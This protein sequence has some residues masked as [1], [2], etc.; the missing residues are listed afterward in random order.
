MSFIDDLKKPLPSA[1]TRQLPEDEVVH[2]SVEDMDDNYGVEDLDNMGND[3]MKIPDD[4]EKPDS[5]ELSP[6]ED[7]EADALINIAATPVV[8]K[9]LLGQESVDAFRESAEF[10][11]AIRE[12]FALEGQKDIFTD[13]T[14]ELFTEAKFY[15]KN[16]V[17]FTKEARTNQLFEVCVQAIARAKNDPVYI[18]LAK[19]QELRRKLK[20]VLRQR[21]KQPAMKKA[22][23]YVLR[24]RKSNSPS[25]AKIAETI[26]NNKN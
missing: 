12:G 17:K 7:A 8:M 11:I 1:S 6:D 14:S 5:M 13:F 3:D 21:Y 25:L 24:L 4:L 15:T 18:K 9:E 19:V 20:A 22:K 10:D 16:Q 26:T 23:E 2:E